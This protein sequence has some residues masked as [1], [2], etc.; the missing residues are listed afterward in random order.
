M[1]GRWPTWSAC[2]GRPSGLARG[3]FGLFVALLAV[4]LEVLFC[5]TLA[6]FVTAA[7]AGLLRSRRGK[8][9]AAFLVIPIFA[10]YEIFTQ[11]VPKLTAE[12]KLTPASFAGVDVSMRWIPPGLAAHAIQDAS[13]GT[14]GTALLRLGAARRRRRRA[15]PGC[16]SD[17]SAAAW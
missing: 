1:P 12:G 7:L 5:I 14:P 6:R 11:V 8:D 2:S 16:G 17:P 3:G 9:F 13:P 4:L 10:L 15:R